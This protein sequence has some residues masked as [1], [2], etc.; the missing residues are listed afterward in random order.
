MIWLCLT[1]VYWSPFP[2]VVSIRLDVFV[3]CMP[4]IFCRYPTASCCLFVHLY[5]QLFRK[6]TV[7]PN[8]DKNVSDIDLDRE[9][10]EEEHYS[11]SLYAT[12]KKTKL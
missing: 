9:I 5:I 8:A 11:E 6:V 2:Y 7:P 3:V 10:A 1:S 12:L 4:Y